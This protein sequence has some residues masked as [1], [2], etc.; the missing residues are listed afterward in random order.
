MGN[1]TWTVTHGE[2]T[3]NSQTTTNPIETT[4]L[5]SPCEITVTYTIHTT[6][7]TLDIIETNLPNSPCHVQTSVSPPGGGSNCRDLWFENEDGDTISSIVRDALPL[8][9]NL[10]TS[11]SN[12]IYEY[13]F[14]SSDTTA[15]FTVTSTPGAGDPTQVTG[16]P[17]EQITLFPDWPNWGDLDNIFYNGTQV[18]NNI[19]QVFVPSGP[20]GAPGG[21]CNNWLSVTDGGGGQQCRALHVSQHE[22][23]LNEFNP[24]IE[25]TIET[26]SIAWNGPFVFE[27]TDNQGIFTVTLPDGSTVSNDPENSL[28][29][30]APDKSIAI[31]YFSPN[32]SVSDILTIHDETYSVCTDRITFFSGPG[33]PTCTNLTISPETE[34]INILPFELTNIQIDNYQGNRE[35]LLFHSD[36]LNSQFEITM[37]DGTIHQ[38]EQT[39]T[40]SNIGLNAQNIDTIRYYNGAEIGENIIRVYDPDFYSAC[41]DSISIDSPLEIENDQLNKNIHCLRP[42]PQVVADG[43]LVTYRV[44]YTPETTMIRDDFTIITDTSIHYNPLGTPHY[45]IPGQLNPFHPSTNPTGNYIEISS[46]QTVSIPICSVNSPPPGEFCYT[47]LIRDPTGITFHNLKSNPNNPPPS[48]L[49]EYTGTVHSQ[50]LDCDDLA[51]A[52]SCSMENFKNHAHSEAFTITNPSQPT[53]IHDDWANVWTVCPYLLTRNAGDVFFEEPFETGIDVSCIVNEIRNTSGLAILQKPS[54]PT[55]QPAELIPTGQGPRETASLCDDPI[56]LNDPDIINLTPTELDQLLNPIHRFSSFVC[57]MQ[58]TIEEIWQRFG[59][60]ANPSEATAISTSGRLQNNQI[61]NT[62]YIIAANTPP[63][64]LDLSLAHLN[65]QNTHPNPNRDIFVFEGDLT[66]TNPSGNPTNNLEITDPGARTIIVKNGNL[67]I[68]TNLIYNSTNIA[69]HQIPSIAFIVTDGNIYIHPEV[70][71]L[72]GVFYT[73]GNLES[74]DATGNETQSLKRLVIHGS[75]YGNLEPLFNKRTF[76][77]S[78]RRELG[79]IVIYYDAR[80]LLNT[81]PGLEDF[82]GTNWQEVAR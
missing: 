7:S 27:T 55:P 1:F 67:I 17:I 70:T 48:I 2:L 18:G 5:S 24:N 72:A 12:A 21:N 71:K 3:Y 10:R 54:I 39:L 16:N 65:L 68:N 43:A 69:Y 26:Q 13:T 15:L 82:L 66:L 74:R 32:P 76:T 49:I 35:V 9:F 78:P 23:N 33:G 19:I 29:V 37:L 4:C 46:A 6:D 57:E 34:T 36:D 73:E 42:N 50:S 25:F 28:R 75:V 11:P 14:R 44:N 60:G 38:H 40:V 41:H 62:R 30:Y 22:F 81:P 8:T 58:L 63:P 20:N 47:G 64:L 79:N 53:S 45:Y 59:N 80:I 61:R 51:N 31:T 52:P 77:G 56:D